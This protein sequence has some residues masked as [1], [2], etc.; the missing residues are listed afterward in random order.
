MKFAVILTQYKRSYLEKQLVSIKNQTLQPDYLFVFQNEKHNDIKKL[1]EKYD[2]IHILNEYNTKYFGRFA[3][4]LNLPVDICIVMDD[5]IIPG[6]QYLSN[7]TNECIR[8]NG[9]IGGNGRI[10][11]LNTKI[12]K[13]QHYK[14]ADDIHFRYK[15]KQVDFVGHCWT[16]KKDWL[17]YMFGSKPYTTDTGEDMHFCYSAKL[18]G[19]IN[20]YVCKQTNEDEL[21]DTSMNKLAVDE[22]ANFRRNGITDLRIEIEK[23][24]LNKGLKLIETN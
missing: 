8:L 20:S 19:G 13:E 5:D 9:I 23:Y 17:Y 4:C 3:F 16:F 1:K 12:N 18:F 24:W 10:G 2:F 15:T 11:Y 22:H 21:C 7:V 14:E 6:K